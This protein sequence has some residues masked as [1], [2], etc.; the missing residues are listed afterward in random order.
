M[1]TFNRKSKTLRLLDQLSA[2][3]TGFTFDII[4]I[5]NNSV[6]GT[7]EAIFNLDNSS[8]RL[9][10]TPREMYWAESMNYGYEHIVKCTD[11]DFL[12][13]LNDDIVLF[14]DWFIKVSEDIE[15][16]GYSQYVLAYS[17]KDMNSCHSYG[18]LQ[19]MFRLIK[20]KLKQVTP[21]GEF[22]RVDTLNFN[23]VVTP[24]LL[25]EREGF[26]CKYFVHGLADFDF[27]LRMSSVGVPVL[28]S[29]GYLG[30]CNRNNIEGTSADLSLPFIDRVRKLH[31]KKEQPVIPRVIYY[32]RHDKI[33][34]L[35]SYFFVYASFLKSSCRDFRNNTNT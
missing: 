10:S 22:Q 33:M 3:I 17:F 32:I 20:T 19:S 29:G 4:V 21:N 28:I 8:I 5:D 1:A 9:F 18:G 23:F 34:S 24:R 35:L 7:R 30:I 25:L 14:D 31:S 26:L 16:L 11:Y 15:F 27:G 12:I 13:S 2:T 6:D